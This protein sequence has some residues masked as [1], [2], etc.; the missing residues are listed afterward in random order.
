[1]GR[2]LEDVGSI[3]ACTGE[4]ISR[5]RGKRC[6]R[7][8]P[9]VYGGTRYGADGPGGHRG[10]SPRVRGNRRPPPPAARRNAA[11]WVYPRVYGGTV[12]GGEQ[13]SGEQGLSPRVRG[14]RQWRGSPVARVGSIPACTGEPTPPIQI[15]PFPR[16]YPRVYGGTRP[17][18]CLQRPRPGLSPR[19][20]GNLGR[21]AAD[22]ERGRSIPACT[23]E[24]SGT[25]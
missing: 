8:Y 2:F 24:P 18:A 11:A 19:V 12:G 25:L 3:P 14:N 23:G 20:R 1:M 5:R 15:L 22:V 7:V 9:R 21:L 13:A 6:G 16:V 10:L 4:P 17:I